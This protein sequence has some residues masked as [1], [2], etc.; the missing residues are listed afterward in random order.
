MEVKLKSN[1]AEGELFFAGRLD[2]KTA[3]ETEKL[4]AQ[5]AA[6]YEKLVFNLEKLEYMSSAGIRLVIMTFK[7][8]KKKGGSLVL[9][10]A[11]PQIIEIFQLT[12]L[13]P[14][15]QFEA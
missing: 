10:K 2:S 7:A 14:M 4:L 1:G 11:R 5:M 8:M 13:G 15:L 6:R 3:P 12:G 9:R